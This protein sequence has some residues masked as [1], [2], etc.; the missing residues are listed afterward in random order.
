MDR[1]ADFVTRELLTSGKASAPSA[2]VHQEIFLAKRS[3]VSFVYIRTS[4]RLDVDERGALPARYLWA[5]LSARI[6]PAF[7]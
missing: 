3:S 7:S 1:V 6:C 4:N 5:M 2:F